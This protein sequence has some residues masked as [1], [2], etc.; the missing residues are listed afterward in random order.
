MDQIR[1]QKF[2][3]DC[4]ILSRRAAEQ[5]IKDGK[6]LINGIPAEIGQKISPDTD[7]VEY[8]GRVITPPEKSSYTYV[9]LNKPRGFLS[10][11]TDDIPRRLSFSLH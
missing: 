9:M 7:I 4:D 1:I 6:I 2:F 11:V 8:E 10:T 5:A 3:T